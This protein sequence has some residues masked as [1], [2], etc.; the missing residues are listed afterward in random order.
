MEPWHF[1]TFSA[2]RNPDDP[3]FE[4]TQLTFRSN[5]AGR[6]SGV[7][8]RTDPV[9]PETTFQR[10]PPARFA[11]PAYLARLAGRFVNGPTAVTIAVAGNR[12]HFTQGAVSSALT[13]KD[14]ARWGLDVAPAIEMEFVTDANGVVTHLRV[15]QPGAVLDLAKVPPAGDAG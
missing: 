2:L 4:G 11:D 1:E 8:W 12:L 3:A 14:D 10:Q 7:Q 6:I 9:V 5:A 13:P 15:I